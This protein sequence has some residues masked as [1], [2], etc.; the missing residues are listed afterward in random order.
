MSTPPGPMHTWLVVCGGSPVPGRAMEE[1]PG[2]TGAV[3]LLE[4]SSLA[5]I[6]G[7]TQVKQRRVT[8]TGV[9]ATPSSVQPDVSRMLVRHSGARPTQPQHGALGGWATLRMQS[10]LG[11]GIPGLA[12]TPAP[13]GPT[14]SWFLHQPPPA[15]TPALCALLVLFCLSPL[16]PRSSP[17]SQEQ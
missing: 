13:E 7:A 3:A 11:P 17:L 1:P 10:P 8:G 2:L 9:G 12:L 6:L 14:I 15:P 16:S 4:T 5:D